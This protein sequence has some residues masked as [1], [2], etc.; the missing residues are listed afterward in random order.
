MLAPS[1]TRQGIL[2]VLRQAG[3]A[4]TAPPAGGSLALIGPTW[5]IDGSGYAF[6]TPTLGANLLTNGDMGS[7]TGWTVGSGWAIAAGVATKTAGAAGN[8][9]QNVITNHRWYSATYTLV[10]T[11][12]TFGALFGTTANRGI[13]RTASG[14]YTDTKRGDGTAAGGLRAIT[15]TSAGTADDMSM[16]EITANTLF[17]YTDPGVANAIVAAAVQAWTASTQVGVFANMDSPANPQ[18]FLLA[19]LTNA[20]HARLVK[21]VAGVY[22]DVVAETSITTFVA[23]AKLEIRRPSGNTYQLWYNNAQVGTDQTVSDAGIIS[24]T[25]CGI[26]STYSANKISSLEV[27]GANVPLFF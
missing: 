24:N 13:D 14:T 9:S 12:S 6:N 25:Y 15:T 10:V 27:G 11:A 5:A 7:A 4:P 3:T 2:K 22:S 16:R 26:A 19:T 1:T 18:N 23:N 8:L 20:N 21:C 17:A